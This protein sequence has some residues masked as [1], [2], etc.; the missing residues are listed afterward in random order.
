M[1]R[2]A[3]RQLKAEQTAP[4]TRARSA[5][6]V[7]V[8][9]QA[10]GGTSMASEGR[11]GDACKAR[12]G[13]L[14]RAEPHLAAFEPRRRSTTREPLSHLVCHVRVQAAASGADRSTG[15]RERVEGPSAGRLQDPHSRKVG[16]PAGA[17]LAGLLLAEEQ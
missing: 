4:R 2:E 14:G 6:E 5:V 13:A 7:A 16:D 11:T 17:E 9:A 15:R 10:S 3:Y 8:H 1:A 12:Q